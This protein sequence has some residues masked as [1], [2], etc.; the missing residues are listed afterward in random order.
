LKKEDWPFQN[1]KEGE[2]SGQKDAEGGAILGQV[3]V[4][5]HQDSIDEGALHNNKS[6]KEIQ[7]AEIAGEFLP[8]HLLTTVWLITL[9]LFVIIWVK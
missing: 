8:R 6:H 7:E 3:I 2:Q 5:L 1:K 9:V 4:V